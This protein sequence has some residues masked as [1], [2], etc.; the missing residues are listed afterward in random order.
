[1]PPMILSTSGIVYCDRFGSNDVKKRFN[2]VLNMLRKASIIL[3]WTGV[4]AV[5]NQS[6]MSYVCMHR[7]S[8]HAEKL[9]LHVVEDAIGI[10]KCN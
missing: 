6:L 7:V 4:I 2:T 8:K 9:C 10:D 5:K 1:M 3:D